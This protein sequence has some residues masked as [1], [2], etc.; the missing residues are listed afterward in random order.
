MLKHLLDQNYEQSPPD[1][2]IQSSYSGIPASELFP[3]VIRPQSHHASYL[4]GV[5][6]LDEYLFTP[7]SSSTQSVSSPYDM[8]TD[9][10][11]SFTDP[12]ASAPLPFSIRDLIA[13][14][15]DHLQIPGP[16]AVPLVDTVGDDLLRQW[17]KFD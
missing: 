14:A 11:V 5:F 17:T 3:G 4:F 8:F 10:P 2:S 13:P 12:W 6:E 9:G 1:P 15:E 7:P 16:D